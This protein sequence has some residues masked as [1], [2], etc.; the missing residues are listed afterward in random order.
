MNYF[1]H[2]QHLV[3]VDREY[4]REIVELGLNKVP[5]FQEFDLVFVNGL[6]LPAQDLQ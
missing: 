1:I 6:L 5:G 2:K 3:M 4:C